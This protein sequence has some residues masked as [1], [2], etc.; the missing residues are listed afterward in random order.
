MSVCFHTFVGEVI[1]RD[2]LILA[3]QLLS[4]NDIDNAIWILLFPHDKNKESSAHLGCKA[5]YVK[6]AC[7]RSR[8][9]GH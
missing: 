8:L 6:I 3:F 9:T 7:S 4:I 2:A 5:L 1:I